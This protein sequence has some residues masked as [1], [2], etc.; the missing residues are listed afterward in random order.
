MTPV[1]WIPSPSDLR[2]DA[3]LGPRCW[4]TPGLF[5]AKP[6]ARLVLRL[7]GHRI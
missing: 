1:R 7:S 4:R 5:P 6:S 3:V 2:P